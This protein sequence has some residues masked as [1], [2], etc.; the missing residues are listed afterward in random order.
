MTTRQY[1]DITVHG[2]HVH[3][4]DTIL[5]FN[6]G[7]ELTET[8]Q[9]CRVLDIALSNVCDGPTYLGDLRSDIDELLNAISTIQTC[10]EENSTSEILMS[11]KAQSNLLD[12][13]L[14]CKT[15]KQTLATFETLLTIP[16]SESPSSHVFAALRGALRGLRRRLNTSI[17][18]LHL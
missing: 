6:I 4:G 14:A 5:N 16:G 3:A 17:A 8:A 10:I 15:Q 1:G 18:I 12:L 7:I 2:G 9:S 11:T 13:W